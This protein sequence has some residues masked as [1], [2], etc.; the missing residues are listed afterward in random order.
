MTSAPDRLAAHPHR[1]R[2]A[3]PSGQHRR[4]G[5]RDAA[6]WACRGSCWSTR[7]AFPIP[8]RS[9][10]RRAR[11]AVLDAARRR[12][13]ARRRARR[14][15]A[16]DRSLGAAARVRGARAAGARCRRAKRSRTRRT[17]TSRSCSAPRC[18]ACPTPSSRAAA[19]VATIPA[20][21]GYASLNL[22]AAVQVAAYELRA[23][24]GRRRR[25]ARAALRA[26][27][28]RRDRG[29]VRARARA[30]SSRCASSIRGC[31]SACC[32]GCGG[33]VRARRRS[34]RRRSTS[35]AAFS[36]GSISCS[37]G[38]IGVTT[39]QPHAIRFPP[40]RRAAT[41]APRRRTRTARPAARRRA[42]GC[43]RSRNSC[44]KR[45]AAT[46]RSTDAV[47][48]ARRA[49]VPARIPHPRIS[50]RPP[51]ALRAARRGSSWSRASLLFAVL[52]IATESLGRP[53]DR[54]G[55]DGATGGDR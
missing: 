42:R 25:V 45:P 27:D 4:R 44:A 5:A 24:R 53:D 55:F 30:R 38:E 46:S 32:R 16:G 15:R 3:E 39:E 6:R 52:R 13:H 41:A 40:S 50:R 34:R 48:D 54:A 28:R 20:N 31:R 17:A 49:P 51:P 19:I 10:S 18:R 29:A 35:C 14:L 11:R 1:A 36:R 47:E 7:G 37:S 9:R 8:R 33:S 43:R 22:A 21:A 23:R 12:R 26:R 2:R